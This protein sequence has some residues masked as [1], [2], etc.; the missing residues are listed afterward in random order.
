MEST[1]V[2]VDR[3]QMAS[4]APVWVCLGHLTVVNKSD[5]QFLF[6][7]HCVDGGLIIGESPPLI[8]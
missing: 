6:Y 1:N 8:G 2:V 5:Q 7:S 3:F 4:F